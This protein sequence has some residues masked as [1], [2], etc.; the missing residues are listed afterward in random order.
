MSIRTATKPNLI[1][2]PNLPLFQNDRFESAIWLKGA[3]VILESAIECPCKGKTGS[4]LVT[5][6]NCLGLGWVFLNPLATKAIVS[7]VNY[8]TKYS[9]WSPEL[10]GTISITVRDQER[11]S[12]MDKVTFASRTSILS[13]VRPVIDTGTQKFIFCSY[14]VRKIKSIY[15]FNSDATKLLKLSSD[16]YTIKSDNSMVVQLNSV[17]Y[18]TPFNGVVSIE[19]EHAVAYHIIDIPHDV[20]S[21]FLVNSKGQ[22][23][24]VNL[25]LQGIARRAHLV[26][27][28]STNYAGTNLLDNND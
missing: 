21:T 26:F 9:Q 25:P 5:C 7:S 10:T 18:P 27:G 6:Q 3:D 8:K 4:P 22:N 11:F 1:G 2:T 12:F 14:N 20:R 19:Y 28:Q 15:I 24:E 17:S 13:E 23:E 16:K